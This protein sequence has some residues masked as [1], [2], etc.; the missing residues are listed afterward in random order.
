V[1]PFAE[2]DCPWNKN[3]DDRQDLH[4]IASAEVLSESAG[5]RLAAR[6]SDLSATGCYVDTINPLMDGTP[7]H[8]K[9]LIET[10]V[11]EAPATVVYSHA[12]LGMGLMFGEVLGDS[13][14]VL[15]N[16][17]PLANHGQPVLNHDGQGTT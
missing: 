8:L 3:G 12:H 14:K 2:G 9:I 1:L 16:W 10:R 17:L 11:F 4:F 13:Q 5:T 6:I 7:V 15:Q